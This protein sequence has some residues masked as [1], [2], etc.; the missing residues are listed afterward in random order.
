MQGKQNSAEPE[1]YS[2]ADKCP[3]QDT[4]S[5]PNPPTLSCYI[6]YERNTDDRN[7]PETNLD[8]SALLLSSLT[9]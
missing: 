6:G 5:T 2:M 3:S 4:P 8:V 7:T 9:R 1:I